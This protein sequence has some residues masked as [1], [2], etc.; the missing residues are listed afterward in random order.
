MAF[1]FKKAQKSKAK[2]RMAITGAT[3]SGKTFTALRIAAGLGGRTLVVDTEGGE[4]GSANKYADKF[5]FDHFTLTTFH[6]ATLTEV[7]KQAM[8]DG[9][10]NLI[11]DSMSHFWTGKEGVLDQVD[12]AAKRSR[13]GNSYTAWKEGTP[14][15]RAMVDSILHSNMHVLATMR[16]KMDYIL[17][18]QERNGRTYQVPKRVGMAPIQRDDVAYEFDVVGDMDR[19]EMVVNKTRCSDLTDKVIKHPGEELGKQLLAWLSDGVEEEPRESQA[20]LSVQEPSAA[21]DSVGT[22][23]TDAVGHDETD[24]GPD[25]EEAVPRY[26]GLVEQ[27]KTRNGEGVA[28]GEKVR[29]QLGFARRSLEEHLRTED[30]EAE[31]G[32]DQTREF[33]TRHFGLDSHKKVT[34]PQLDAMFEWMREC[35]NAG[36]VLK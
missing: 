33:L 25:G 28:W 3:G 30:S 1:V 5:D 19:G 21:G 11:I 16:S 24:A 31:F 7:I 18:T 8:A 14:M 36:E 2:L 35:Y 32:V 29:K 27:A 12:H 26:V 34:Q 4:G 20:G 22:T 6:P 9:Y 15:Q 17:E 10:N 13:T 23:D